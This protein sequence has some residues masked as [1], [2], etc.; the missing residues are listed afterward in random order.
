MLI[1]P[2]F[3]CSC[4]LYGIKITWS[5]QHVPKMAVLALQLARSQCDPKQAS[6][7]WSQCD[8]EPQRQKNL[9]TGLL[10]AHIRFEYV[11]KT[12][13]SAQHIPK[14][15][16]LDRQL[17]WSQCDQKQASSL[18]SQCDQEPQRQ[19]NLQTWLLFPCSCFLNGIKNY[20]ERERSSENG[21]PGSPACLVTV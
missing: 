8:Q 11:L 18:W 17:A 20:V 15:A 7:L 10:F 3:A 21:S 6:C 12:T 9:H 5:A 13:L 4:F 16:F 1:W 2:F 14:L 19:E